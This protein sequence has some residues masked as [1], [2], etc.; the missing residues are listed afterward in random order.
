MYRVMNADGEIPEQRLPAQRLI[1]ETCVKAGIEPGRLAF[2]ADRGQVMRSQAVSQLLT[3][4]EVFR[5]HSRPHVSHDN[6][7]FESQF[8]TMKYR[9]D[10]PDRFASFDHA[11]AFCCPFFDWYNR[12]H[13]PLRH[14]HSRPELV[15]CRRIHQ[16]LATRQAMLDLAYAAHPERF[17]R[18]PPQ[19]PRPPEA[20]W[21]NRPENTPAIAVTPSPE[22]VLQ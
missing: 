4:L 10:F 6:P 5:S 2:H 9:P 19:V 3:D 20:A 11:R 22:E 15:H 8:K 12:G 14:R 16:A 13:R 18:R 7:Y 1:R 21:I 17:V